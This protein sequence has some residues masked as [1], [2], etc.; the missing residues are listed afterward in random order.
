VLAS[1]TAHH[2]DSTYLREGLSDCTHAHTDMH[3]AT[4]FKFMIT[5]PCKESSMHK[6]Y[7]RYTYNHED[8]QTRFVLC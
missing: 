4:I 5:K 7:R 8:T 2:P 6:I 1:H 3:L